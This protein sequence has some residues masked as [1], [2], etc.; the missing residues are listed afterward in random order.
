[1][2]SLFSLVI[3]ALCL[4]AVAQDSNTLTTVSYVAGNSDQSAGSSGDGTTSASFNGPNS[5][6]LDKKGV[7]NLY[8]ADTQNHK[9]RFISG[10]TGIIT[11][12]AG[13]GTLGFSGDNGAAT[14]ANL[15]YPFTVSVDN[16]NNYYIADTYNNRIR[17]VTSTSIISTFAGTG[18]TSAFSS[19]GDGGQATSATLNQPAGVAMNTDYSVLYISDSNSH[20]I[21]RVDLS[22]K[23][24]T[25]IAGT[26]TFG[27][28]GDIGPATSAKLYF[29]KGLAVDT[30]NNLY[31]A[32]SSN[33]VVR[34]VMTGSCLFPT[35]S[36]TYVPSLTTGATAPPTTVKPTSTPTTMCQSNYIYNVAGVGGATSSSVIDGITATSA[37]LNFPAGVV[38]DKSKNIYI[39][40]TANNRIRKVS[41]NYG[42]AIATIAG[43]AVTTGSATG[44]FGTSTLLSYPCGVAYDSRSEYQGL[45]IADTSYNRVLKLINA[46]SFSPTAR[47]TKSPTPGP[48]AKPTTAKPSSIP[49]EMPTSN[50]TYAPTQQPTN[51]P[52]EIPTAE[53]STSP[54]S[55]PTQVP[56]VIPSFSP[57]FDPTTTPTTIPTLIP[58]IIPTILP[59]VTPTESPS[60][61]PTSIPTPLP[62]E[63]TNRP[64][65]GSPTVKPRYD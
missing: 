43:T 23:I 42:N 27:Y 28:S 18:S 35:A 36:P 21:R 47:P 48:S 37:Y 5:I 4:N 51:F 24:I 62:G 7:G 3:I 9:I 55:I 12:I 61:I 8:I 49:S 15:Y 29:P 56:T 52:S 10:T 32:D 33:H 14:S 11:T 1:M 39:A 16:S 13:T 19:N 26:S 20:T 38:T 63:P 50:P 6:A 59:T 58:S 31:I 30:D 57:S 64:S 46:P 2:K 40:D 22:T 53:P 41:V 34:K 17:Y 44:A 54:S 25:T 45:L 60:I 65:T